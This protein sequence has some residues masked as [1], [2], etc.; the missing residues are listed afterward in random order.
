MGFWVFFL[1]ISLLLCIKTKK[2]NE[3]YK[4]YIFIF[5][6]SA[7]RFDVG[8]DYFSY[9]FSIK[10]L[11][12]KMEP[13]Y[14]LLIKMSNFY[15]E[16]QIAFIVT[17]FFTVLF[18]Y[19]GIKESKDIKIQTYFFITLL[20]LES[21][22][23][24][25]YILGYSILFYS[26]KYINNSKFIKYIIFIT[27]AG[28]IHKVCYI[29]YFFYFI[30]YIKIDR[31]KLF[32]YFFIC[33][34]INKGVIEIIKREKIYVNYFKEQAKM[35][36]K[37][38]FLYLILAII[39]FIFMDKTKKKLEIKIYFLCIAFG[40]FLKNTSIIGAL[41]FFNLSL[42]YLIYIFPDIISCFKNK[43]IVKSFF[44]ICS[45]FIFLFNIYLGDK[46]A[47]KKIYTPY[48]VYFNKNENDFK[49]K[50]YD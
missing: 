38:I 42:F 3:I 17:S 12:V 24:Q 18:V 43:K 23:A 19:M 15:S 44:Y 31:I 34:F 2:N 26:I 48:R 1:A 9:W 25:R 32:F 29:G 7:I 39:V 14:N 35:G 40:I 27:I 47:K 36:D 11:S 10:N 41:R 5:I 30:K 37:I 21:L 22:T 28:M 16:P 45:S 49:L 8:Y 50:R 13:L 6:I 4:V 20:Y 46:N 33:F